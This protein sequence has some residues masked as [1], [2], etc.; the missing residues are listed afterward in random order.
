MTMLEAR[1]RSTLHHCVIDAYFF[2]ISGTGY[3]PT[4]EDVQVCE[5]CFLGHILDFDENEIDFDDESIVVVDDYVF[6][7]NA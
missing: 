6:N 2:Y 7:I 1:N 4:P 3:E 5:E